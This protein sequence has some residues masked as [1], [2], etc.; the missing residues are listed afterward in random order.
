MADARPT[1]AVTEGN[2][3]ASA[4]P[5]RLFVAA[6]VLGLALL[7]VGAVLFAM[8]SKADSDSDSDSSVQIVSQVT[9][10]VTQYNTYDAADLAD[11]QKR[12]DG[13]MTKEFDADNDK[14]TALFFDVLKDK[15]QTS[16]D[17]KIKSIA[18]ESADSDS[19]KVLVAVD[20]TVANTDLGK[21]TL[22]QMRWI[23]SMQFEDGQWRVDAFESVA[24]QPASG[25]AAGATPT[26]TAPTPSQ[27]AK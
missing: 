14:T 10:F 19:A 23:V 6:A 7:V 25:Q 27:D 17:P 15:K 2:N 20:A 8:P 18:I 21:P 13:L 5:P 26:P 9:D 22:S 3:S 11:Y 4:R 24:A 1:V 12:L 16:S